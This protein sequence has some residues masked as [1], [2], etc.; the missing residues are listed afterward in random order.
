MTICMH[1]RISEDMTSCQFVM[2]LHHDSLIP[3]GR[4]G[5]GASIS[6]ITEQVNKGVF[7]SA[8]ISNFNFISCF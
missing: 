6:Q 8:P 5:L 7:V 4:C 2:T 3:H 1:W